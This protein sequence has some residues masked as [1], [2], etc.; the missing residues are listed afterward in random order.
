MR[1]EKESGSIKERGECSCACN[2]KRRVLYEREITT[3]LIA[4]T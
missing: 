3:R 2:N 1:K 4:A